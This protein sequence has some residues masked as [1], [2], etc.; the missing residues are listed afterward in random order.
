MNAGCWLRAD[1]TE[2]KQAARTLALDRAACGS[3]AGRI[4]RKSPQADRLSD[5]V[6]HSQSVPSHHGSHRGTWA[7]I[8]KCE[9]AMSLERVFCRYRLALLRPWHA[10]IDT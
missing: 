1:H 10:T 3:G 2:P 4:S 6:L 7:Q 8:G 5:A 9:R